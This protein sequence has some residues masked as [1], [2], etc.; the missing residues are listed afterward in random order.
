MALNSLIRAWAPS[1]IQSICLNERLP[2]TNQYT[3]NRARTP[4]ML[5][6]TFLQ[7]AALSSLGLFRA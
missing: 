7:Q 2:L 3:M 6:G 4:Y 5:G 1:M